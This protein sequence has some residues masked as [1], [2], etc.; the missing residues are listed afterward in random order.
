MTRHY[1]AFASN[2]DTAQMAARCPG[3]E[4]LGPAVLADHRFRIGRRGY[5]T[6]VPEADATVHGILWGLLARHEA[7][8]DVY[9]GVRHGLYRKVSLLV[10]DASGAERDAIVYVAGDSAGA[11]PVPGYMEKVVAAAERHG[12]PT[13][14]VEELRSWLP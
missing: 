7:A 5:A 8:L 1:F 9:E 13:A 2:M 6:V 12:L 14:Y 3:A 10:R 4:C 11:K